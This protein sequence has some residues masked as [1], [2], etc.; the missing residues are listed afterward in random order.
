[1]ELTSYTIMINPV[2]NSLNGTVVECTDL[3][4]QESPSSTVI[5]V[6]QV[7]DQGNAVYIPW[8]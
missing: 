4:D 3:E 5:N 1:M 7:K 8:L 6:V 2:T